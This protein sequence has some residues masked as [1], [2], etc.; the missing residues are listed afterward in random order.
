VLFTIT[1][2]RKLFHLLHTVLEQRDK[3]LIIA[4]QETTDDDNDQSINL[5]LLPADLTKFMGYSH[6]HYTESASTPPDK[7][8]VKANSKKSSANLLFEEGNAHF[9]KGELDSA[10]ACYKKAVKIKPSFFQARYNIAAISQNRGDFSTAI[11]EYEK[12]IRIRPEAIDAYYNLGATL[13]NFKFS[14]YKDKLADVILEILKQEKFI[15]PSEVS[16]SIISLLKLKPNFR[17]ILSRHKT[18][19]NLQTTVEELSKEALFLKLISVCPIADSEIESLLVEIRSLA[20]LNIEKIEDSN[21]ICTTLSAIALH[22]FCNEYVYN[23]TDSETLALKELEDKIHKKIFQNINPRPTE[24]LCL[25]GYKT[26]RG[27]AWRSSLVD[28][29]ELTDVISRHIREIQ[30]EEAIRNYIPVLEETTNQVS[31]NVQGQYE[32]YPYPRWVNLRL[33][34]EPLSIPQISGRIQLKI[35]NQTILRCESPEVLIAGCG[36]GQQ[37]IE[38]ASRYKNSRVLA[39]D[40]SL[41]SLSYA[42]RKTDELGIQNIEYMRADILDLHKLGRQFDVIESCGVLH[43]MSDPIEGWQRLVECLSSG[44][45][46]K[47]ALYSR[48]ARVSIAKIRKEIETLGVTSDSSAMKDFRRKV[49]H[50]SRED[51]KYIRSFKDFYCLSELRDLL[52]HVEEHQFTIPQIEE[53]LNKL[54]LVFCGFESDY[55]INNFKSRAK[56]IETLYDLKAWDVFENENQNVFAGMYQFWCQKKID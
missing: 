12:V 32:A 4:A 30:K 26:L 49:I 7:S 53:S 35:P 11:D 46:L 19:A 31:L 45:L 9:V 17:D 54:G 1:Q 44:G 50:S 8:M 14:E 20:L 34:K 47:I 15:R 38:A 6:L 28:N 13:R 27:Y 48:L 37:S 40:L 23:Q 3:F 39:I 25:A 22:C 33:E 18:E 16:S 24:I 55:I 56:H 51:H 2:L 42:K 21:S 5:K 41:K 43:H 29:G 36:T 52:F 10:L